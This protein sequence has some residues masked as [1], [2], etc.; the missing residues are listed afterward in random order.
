MLKSNIH[1][2]IFSCISFGIFPSIAIEGG[3]ADIKHPDSFPFVHDL[4]NALTKMNFYA[5]IDC[6]LGLNQPPCCPQRQQDGKALN[7]VPEERTN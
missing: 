6:T 4:T 3:N 1:V 7:Q 5:D 2:G